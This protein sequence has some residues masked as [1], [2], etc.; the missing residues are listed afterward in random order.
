MGG[1]RALRGWFRWSGHMAGAGAEPQLRRRDVAQ[2]PGGATGPIAG[3]AGQASYP[4]LT[5]ARRFVAKG[6]YGP[7]SS[8]SR[9]LAEPG[10]TAHLKCGL[11]CG[12]WTQQ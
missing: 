9:D 7:P 11:S 12:L 8:L 3:K 10:W 2:Q 1:V 5:K 4:R 6:K